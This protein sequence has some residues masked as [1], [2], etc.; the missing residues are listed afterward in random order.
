MGYGGVVVVGHL[1]S[2]PVQLHRFLLLLEQ[3]Y[4]IQS[5]DSVQAA[6]P[7]SHAGVP[8]EKW[9]QWGGMGTKVGWFNRT[10]SLCMCVCT[11]TLYHTTPHYTTHYNTSHF[12]TLYYTIH[13]TILHYTIIHYT[14]LLYTTPY[15]YTVIHY[16]PLLYTIPQE[17]SMS[18]RQCLYPHR[19]GIKTQSQ[20]NSMSVQQCLYPH[21]NG[22]LSR[23]HSTSGLRKP[24]WKKTKSLITSKF[25]GRVA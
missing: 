11:T 17:N 13:Y 18:V 6:V 15:Y 16:T 20:E 19:N 7:H 3:R 1:R 21:R 23:F 14:P 24:G 22:W 9:N 5:E 10:W 2:T 4:D 25:L 12:T 8:G